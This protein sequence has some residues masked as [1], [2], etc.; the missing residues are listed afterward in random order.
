MSERTTIHPVTAPFVRD[1]LTWLTYLTNAYG[2]YSVAAMS[3]LMA[4]LAVDLSLNYTQRGLH[5]SAFAV[6]TILAGIL[7]DRAAIRFSRRLLMWVG[8]AGLA[9]GLLTLVLAHTP[10]LTIAGV[11]VMGLLGT[12]MFVMGQ[13]TLADHQDENRGIAFTESSVGASIAGFFAPLLISLAESWALG[14]RVAVLLSPLTWASMFMW[15]R[16]IAVPAGARP[17][18]A[19]S[20]SRRLS[21]LYWVFWTMMF[22]GAATE[23]SVSFWTPEFLTQVVGVDDVTAAGALSL[24]WL[25][26]I[27]GRVAGTLLS[28]RFQPITLLLGA[29]ALVVIAFPL[30]WLARSST[31]AFAALFALSLGLANF[32]PLMLALATAAGSNNINAA[33]ARVALANGVAILI[34]PQLLGS[35]GDAVGIGPAFAL[36][37]LLAMAVLGLCVFARRAQ[38]QPMWRSVQS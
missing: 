12:V 6:G 3:P 36:I 28:R 29:A 37:G 17:A 4:F 25:A 11:F 38:R 27:T 21:R 30:L 26:L 5:T 13:A 1:R 32:F 8:G 7:A 20:A 23:W 19:Q 34:A 24:F 16:K 18:A 22:L 35:L 14:W 9:G 10:A 15:G 2:T 31:V 33:T